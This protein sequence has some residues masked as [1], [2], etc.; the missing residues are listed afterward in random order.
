MITNKIDKYNPLAGFAYSWVKIIAQHVEKLSLL[1]LEKGNIDDLPENIEI[2]SLGKEKGAGSLKIFFKFQKLAL[3]LVP[4]SD[5]VFCHMNPEYVI[6][7]AP[8]AK[9]FKKKVIAWHTHDKTNPRIELMEKLADKIITASEKTFPI[10]SKKIISAGHGIDTNFFHAPLPGQET[11]TKFYLAGRESGDLGVFKILSIG[12]I[13]PNK[14]YELLIRLVEELVYKKNIKNIKLNII[15]Q[16]IDESYFNQLKQSISQKNLHGYV[17]FSPILSS[18]ETVGHYQDADVFINLSQTNDVGKN[19]LEA[20][21][22]GTLVLT[23][24]KSFAQILGSDFIFDKT[25]L[26]K[27]VDKIIKLINLDSD[28]KEFIWQSL[29]KE[30]IKNH[31]LNNLVIKVI[32]QFNTENKNKIDNI[33]DVS[34]KNKFLQTNLTVCYFGTYDPIYTRNK[35]NIKGLRENKVKVIECNTPQT[36]NKLK[37][38]WAL[39]KKHKQIKNDYDVMI[40][41]FAGHA[42]MPLAWLLAKLNGKKLILDLFV[43]EYDSVILD[44]KQHPKNSLTAYKLWILDWVSAHLADICLLDADEHVSYFTKLFSMKKNKFRMLFPSCDENIFYPQEKQSNPDNKFIVHYHGS[45]SPIQGV[46]FIVQ[47]AKFLENENIEFN[48]IGRLKNYKKEI[49]LAKSLNIKNVNFIDIIPYKQLAMQMAKADLVLGMFG[50]TEKAMHCSA[51]KIIEGMA[52]KKP[53]VTGDT[54][55]LRELS[56]AGQEN[57]FFCNMAD[58]QDL[59]D[60]ILYVKNN[61]ALTEKIA[62][63]G[64][65]FCLKYLTPKAVGKELIKIINTLII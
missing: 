42:I 2:Y 43:S 17:S 16:I 60:K 57:C 34:L 38:Y 25:N 13:E 11:I 53:V 3:K 21:A 28:R 18:V 12:K 24:N 41:G 46:S 61:P 29:R 52:M 65:K 50:D 8:Y 1:C 9:L 47:S 10:K 22:C 26:E 40:V 20:M 55:A 45:Y 33:S 59:A 31:N 35:L 51:F 23:S 39:I 4:K 7:I 19:I 56:P 62:E 49:E 58:S 14:D 64:Y 5:G 37:K 48:I 54:L 6:A 44:R 63:N 36:P 30:V 32:E 27:L 15:G